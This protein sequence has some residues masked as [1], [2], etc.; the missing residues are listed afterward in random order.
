MSTVTG[1]QEIVLVPRNPTP[2]MLDAAWAD[3][4]AEDAAGVWEA[5]IKCYAESNGKSGAVSG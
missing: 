3:A 4:L 2:E 1:Q 5:M